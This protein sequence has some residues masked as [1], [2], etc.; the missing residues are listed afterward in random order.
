MLKFDIKKKQTSQDIQANNYLNLRIRL[1][2]HLHINLTYAKTL[3][4]FQNRLK[5][6]ILV[7][8]V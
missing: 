7:F 3:V 4:N 6:N 5:I 2:F 8:K 1:R